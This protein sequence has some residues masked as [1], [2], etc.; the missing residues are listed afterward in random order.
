MNALL[1]DIFRDRA[2]FL[3]GQTGFKG[4]WLTIWLHR[5][6]A[7]VTGYAL[8]PPTEPSNFE[9]S[10]VRDLLN[11]Q[12]QADIRDG[13][14]L[15][16]ALSDADP[17]VVFHLAAQ[18]LV[19]ESY[20]R[21]RETFEVNAI[22]IASV[23]DAVRARGKPCVVLIVTS[24]KC[25]E[26]RAQAAGYRE[27]DPLGGHD[28]YSASKGAA[29]LVTAAYRRSFFPPDRLAEHGVK[30]ASARAGN[31]I[32]GGDWAGDRIITDIV[33]SLAAGKPI[34][35]RNPRAVRPWQHVTEPLHGYLTLAARM[36]TSDDPTWCDAWN[37]GPLPG[38]DV[39]V[40][41]LVD[42]FIAAW[43]QGL[44]EDADDSNPPPEAG[45]LR[46]SIDKA[47]EKLGWRPRWGLA[48]AV[49]RTAQ[50]YRRY[51]QGHEK[52]M[53]PACLDDIT[54]YGA[55][56]PMDNNPDSAA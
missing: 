12:H 53:R 54:A 11:A 27:T 46:L 37:F 31:V 42:R 7:R 9:L 5:L 30:L 50:W 4:S 32:G 22:G 17:D 49:R 25:Y 2:V 20:A 51:Y 41:Q 29:E 13:A 44:W 3:T 24:D 39:P 23:L 40:A 35:I 10:G 38:D 16:K 55:A 19:R 28:P 56:K 18:S 26:T 48:E 14:R 45:V 6:G 21:P 36:L 8:A 52:N 34:P 15:Q 47:V 43:G 1:Q 33:R